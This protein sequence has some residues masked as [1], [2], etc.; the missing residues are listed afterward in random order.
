MYAY[1]C[2]ILSLFVINQTDQD[3]I[4]HRAGICRVNG[5]ISNAP[6]YHFL[7]GYMFFLSLIIMFFSK[8]VSLGMKPSP[9]PIISQTEIR[10][11]KE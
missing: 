8:Q 6:F 1:I 10:P 7:F 5:N 9:G 11:H 3:T 4:H 2:T